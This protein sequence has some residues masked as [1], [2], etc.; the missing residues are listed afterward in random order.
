LD[1]AGTATHRLTN[2][3]ESKTTVG[4]QYYRNLFDRNGASGSFLAPGA[5]T[6]TGAG[7]KDNDEATTESRTLGGFVEE[8]LAFRDRL[9]V[10]A[11]VRSDRNSAFGA[12]FKTVFYPKL[13][14]S[15]V[16][17][18]ESF[19][20]QAN[21]IDQ[22]R[23]RSAF[24]A[25]GVQP[26]TTDAVPFY[27][28]TNG[29]SQGESADFT[30]VVITAL[31][32]RNLKP[33]RSTEFE[34][35]LDGTFFNSRLTTEFTF[36]NKSSK[37][38]LVERVLPPSIGTGDTERFENLGEVRNRGL[39]GLVNAR[40]IQRNAFGWDVT[41][42]GSTNDN[43]LISLGGL[44]NI[45]LS[46]TLQNREGYPLN[47][48]WSRRLLSYEDKD[49]NGII[50][51]N[52]NPAVSEIV[53][54]DTNVFNGYSTPKHEIA[55]TNGFDLFNRRI[56]VSGML[57]Y[58]GGYKLYNNTERIRCASRFNCAG[59]ISPDASLLEQARTV[60]VR[61]HPSRSV[62]G[63]LEDGDFIRFR[64]LS[65]SYTAPDSWVSRYLRGR[66]LIVSGSVRNIGT[67]WTK[68]TGVDPEAFGTTGDAPSSFQAFAPP[69][70][71]TLRVNLGF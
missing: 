20:P 41:V 15:W 34:L 46:S 57:Y 1:A 32:N 6:I 35:G 50:T 19:F 55:L 29:R 59:L 13:A 12:D 58:K 53:V 61:E 54:A 28:A 67:I 25:S 17:S 23:L 33:E 37:D 70:Y 40:I 4:M 65:V 27:S 52:S 71:F 9:F 3:L 18:D 47:G 14:V 8:N 5:T 69:S 30:G 62:A 66:S 24:G 51:Y 21:F 38:A 22:L 49:N 26:G 2:S 39:E 31:G 44:P 43:E 56:R 36:Y 10:T 48:W 11:A 42:N 7:D 45:V 60:L 64:E 63:F 16:V 68:Y